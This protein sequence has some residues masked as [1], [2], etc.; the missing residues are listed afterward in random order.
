M[1]NNKLNIAIL[2]LLLIGFGKSEA[3]VDNKKMSNIA[4][5]HEDATKEEFKVY[6]NCG[7]CKKT[8]EGS[9][10]KEEGVDEASWD[11]ET[12]TMTVSYHEAQITLNEIKKKIAGAG[13]D[14]EEF[15]ADKEV[16][17]SLHKCCQY[18]RPEAK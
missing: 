4:S 12:K 8:I 17:E 15:R 5:Y 2:F 13:Y 11:S 6:G 16:Y 10:N 7:M 1:K 14:T 3:K 9:L 18:D